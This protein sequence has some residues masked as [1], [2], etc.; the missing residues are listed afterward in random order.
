MTLKERAFREGDHS[1]KRRQDNLAEIVGSTTW[2]YAADVLRAGISR[3]RH[4]RRHESHPRRRAQ[5]NHGLHHHARFR[6]H[7]GAD[8]AD[9]PV[10]R[11][12]ARPHR[13]R[14][15]ARLSLA[16]PLLPIDRDQAPLARAQR[17]DHRAS[18]PGKL[19]Q[20]GHERDLAVEP[21]EQRL[22]LLRR[23]RQPHARGLQS[24]GR[25]RV[26]A[27]LARQP[28]T[29]QPAETHQGRPQ[30]RP[31]AGPRSRPRRHARADPQEDQERRPDR[32]LPRGVQERL[33]Q[34]ETL[35]PLRPA[36]RTAG[37]PGRDRRTV[38]DGSPDWA[39]KS[40]AATPT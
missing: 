8:P 22:S 1:F 24:A 13:H 32:R 9:R 16:V 30:A 37:R 33:G 7:S 10:R 40:A 6:R 26:A 14:N 31:D 34:G 23:T 20:Y 38:R 12:A 28:S 2:A 4:A 36:R 15:H 39:R 19:S 29:A 27:E 5:R 21:V 3:R 17:R 18:G 35:L 11:N 25:E